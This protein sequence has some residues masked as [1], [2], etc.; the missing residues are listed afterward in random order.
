[1]CAY[2]QSSR[3]HQDLLFGVDQFCLQIEH[4]EKDIA[5][6]VNTQLANK[7]ERNR[8]ILLCIV[9]AILYCGRQ[10]IAL[11]W[12]Q[13]KLGT[14]GNHGNFLGLMTLLSHYDTILQQHVKLPSM[15]GV[16]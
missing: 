16:T 8:R 14:P 6:L 13:E 10:C 4:P 1:M 12:H 7:V 5:A 9:D 2:H 3:S 11:R 15:A